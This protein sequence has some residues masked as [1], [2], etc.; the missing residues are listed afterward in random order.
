MTFPVLV[1]DEMVERAAQKLCEE[2]G[3]ATFGADGL[4]RWRDSARA[5]LEAAGGVR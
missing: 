5:I 3:W 1:T 2:M 4:G